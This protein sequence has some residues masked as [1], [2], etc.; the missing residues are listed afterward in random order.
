MAATRITGPEV[1]KLSPVPAGSYVTYGQER[2]VR[3]SLPAGESSVVVTQ[4]E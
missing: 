1:R 2:F 3:L 4:A